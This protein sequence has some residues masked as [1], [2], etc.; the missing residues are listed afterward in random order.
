MNCTLLW[1]NKYIN[2]F[3]ILGWGLKLITFAFT[4]GVCTLYNTVSCAM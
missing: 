2:K 3:F 4:I 1:N